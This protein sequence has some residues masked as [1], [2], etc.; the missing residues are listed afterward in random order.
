[1]KKIY[2]GIHT[3][4][5]QEFEAEFLRNTNEQARKWQALQQFY[6]LKSLL[7]PDF[8]KRN[9]Q[10]FNSIEAELMREYEKGGEKK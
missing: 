3:Q 8:L 5:P 9:K 6:R 2:T 1:M 7:L 10:S 4:T